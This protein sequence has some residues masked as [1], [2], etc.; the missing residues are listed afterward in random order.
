MADPFNPK[1]GPKGATRRTAVGLLLGAPLLGACAGVQQTLT[2]TFG[3]GNSAQPG[4]AGPAQQPLA[5]GTGQVKVGLILPLSASGNAGIAAQSMK[6]A[7]EM[8]LAE[9]QNPNIQL[10]IKDDAGSAQGA[11]QGTQQALDEGSEIILGPL[12]ALSVPA[13]AQLTRSRNISVIAF[14]TD[15]SVAG[16]GVYLLSFLPESDVNRIVDYAASTGKKSFAAMLPEN[17]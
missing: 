12:F 15:S 7:A 11:Q 17:A 6:N 4:P 13:T 8:A 16:R 9:F 1:S 14:S 10:L 3:T 5:V 2:N